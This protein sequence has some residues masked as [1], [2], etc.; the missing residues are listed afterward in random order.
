VG[1]V[2]T[3]ADSTNGKTRRGFSHQITASGNPINFYA[4]DL[5]QGLS[6]NLTSGIISGIP[7]E[8]GV[9]SV[10]LVASNELGSGTKILSLGIREGE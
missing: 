8:I 4:I 7:I 5:P 10:K 6:C 1:P 3:S 9:F 2:I